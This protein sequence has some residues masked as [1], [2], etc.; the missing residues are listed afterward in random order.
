MRVVAYARVST[1]LQEHPGAQLGEL[2]RVGHARGW[3]IVGE[4]IETASGGDKKRP[5]LAA[6]LGAIRRGEARGL[7]AV[8]MDRIARSV[9][10]LLDIVGDLGA[11]RG[12]LICPRDGQLDTTTAAGR[13]FFHV[14]AAMA[15][16]ERDLARER[17]REYIAVR[18]AQ[19]LP[20][21]RRDTLGPQALQMAISLRLGAAPMPWRSIAG[22][23]ATA[24]MG[25][26]QAATVCRRVREAMGLVRKP[27]PVVNA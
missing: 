11:W 7:V 17:A 13:M 1:K 18:R 19:G 3:E 20:H 9:P 25:N 6:A 12:E 24:G 23:L 16:F 15:E 5:Q 14:R 22:Y 8:S 21:G 2:R 10:H 4:F 27:P 26:H